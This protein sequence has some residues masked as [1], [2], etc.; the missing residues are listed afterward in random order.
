MRAQR[1]VSTSSWTSVEAALFA[2]R[3]CHTEVFCTLITSFDRNVLL[4]V[5]LDCL[6]V[7][8]W[9]RQARMGP[10]MLQAEGMEPLSGPPDMASLKTID[11]SL[12]AAITQAASLLTLHPTLL[13]S[14]CRFISNYSVWVAGQVCLLPVCFVFCVMT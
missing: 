14:Y 6:Q 2:I 13:Q 3:A 11:E 5:C 10:S 7:K 8:S 4:H 1:G 9:Q 12:I